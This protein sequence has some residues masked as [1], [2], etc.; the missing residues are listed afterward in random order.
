MTTTKIRS[1]QTNGYQETIKKGLSAIHSYN[2][3]MSLGKGDDIEQLDRLKEE[4]RAADAIVVGAGAGLSTSAGFTYSGDRFKKWFSDFEEKYGF[5]DMYSGGFYP[6]KT[7]E[8]F[9]AYWSRYI[10][11]NR[12]LDAPK[13]TYTKLY[14]LVKDGNGIFAIPSG[15][16]VRMEIDSSLIPKF[17]IDGSDVTMNLRS[18]DTFFEDEGWHR[19]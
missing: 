5:Q 9:W 8:E 16:V 12:Y 15:G 11:I 13:D 4:I 10:Y 6:Y 14:N 2:S 18:D 17:P 1:F 7:K 19:A 3:G